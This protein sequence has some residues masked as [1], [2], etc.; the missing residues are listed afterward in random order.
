MIAF[1]RALRP[2]QWTKNLLVFA[3]LLFSKHLFEA[4]PFLHASL[5]FVAF[6]GLAGAVYLW[7]DIADVEPDRRHPKK[8]LRPIAA[9][10]LSIRAATLGAVALV[11]ASLSLAFWLN[12][13]LG[14]CAAFYLALNLGY[15]FGMKHVVILDVLALSIGFV[16][17]ALAGGFAVNV[18]VTEWLLVLTLLLALFLALAKRRHEITSL[19]E[20]AAQHRAI[21]A[22][23]SPYLIDQMTSVVTA[24]VV[25]AYTFYTLSPETVSKFGTSKLSWTLPLVLYGIFRY[26]YLVHQKDG[27]DSPTEMLL[28][29]RPLLATV[30]LWVLLVIVIVY[31]AQGVATPL[32]VPT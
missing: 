16:L 12:V 9:G 32:G 17:R 18:P 27:G 11:I 4:Q 28:T 5:A 24:S 23:Y 13:N 14:V 15:S 26:L 20:G 2:H 22:E 3:A 29:D 8:R 25:T 7:N 31:T 10:D 30:A 1:V 21:L 19:G 6:C